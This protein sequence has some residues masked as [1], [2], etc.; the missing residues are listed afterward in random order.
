VT[1]SWSFILQLLQWCKRARAC[2]CVCKCECA[3][4]IFSF[5]AKSV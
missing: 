4:T 1:S 2:V 5:Y 3:F